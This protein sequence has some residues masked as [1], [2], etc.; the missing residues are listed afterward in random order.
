MKTRNNHPFYIIF[1]V[2]IIV[3]VKTGDAQQSKISFNSAYNMLNTGNKYGGASAALDRSSLISANFTN[4]TKSAKV[5][6]G[7]PMEIALEYAVVKA[8]LS[9]EIASNPDNYFSSP[10]DVQQAFSNLAYGDFVKISDYNQ[11]NVKLNFRFNPPFLKIY[12][13]VEEEYTQNS[14]ASPYDPRVYKMPSTPVRG[15]KILVI[16]K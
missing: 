8:N 15:T 10:D 13:S 11:V 6:Y 7:I 14:Y 2:V 1:M 3:L 9:S 5:G 16:K 12:G 4:Y